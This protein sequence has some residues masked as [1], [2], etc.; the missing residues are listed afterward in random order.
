MLSEAQWTIPMDIDNGK[1]SNALERVE[2]QLLAEYER[3]LKVVEQKLTK[4]ARAALQGKTIAGETIADA[5]V[6]KGDYMTPALE[7]KLQ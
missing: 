4:K 6:S 1:L 5:R 7:V 2:K 3:E